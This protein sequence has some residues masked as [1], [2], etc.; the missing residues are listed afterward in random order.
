MDQV[1]EVLFGLGGLGERVSRNCGT[2][3]PRFLEVL[4]LLVCVGYLQGQELRKVGVPI[5]LVPERLERCRVPLGKVPRTM[6]TGPTIDFR[7]SMG[8]RVTDGD[9]VPTNAGRA[10][11]SHRRRLE[12]DVLPPMAGMPPMVVANRGLKA[13][14]VSNCLREGSV[15]SDLHLRKPDY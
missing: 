9:P 8:L 5:L 3:G 1:L 4:L 10:L 15:G 2:S 12:R 7:S 11:W 14:F 13:Q 6:P